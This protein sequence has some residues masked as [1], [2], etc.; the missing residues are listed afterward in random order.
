MGRPVR[1][2]PAALA[3]APWPDVASPD[4]IGEV[5][6][7][8]TLNLREAV[9]S[10]SIRSVAEASGLAHVTLLQ[11]LAGQTWPDLETIAKLERGLDVPLWPR[12]K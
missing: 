12:R 1:A 8:F 9:G 4:P 11:V 5:A 10:R 2:K 7:R 6:R 3:P